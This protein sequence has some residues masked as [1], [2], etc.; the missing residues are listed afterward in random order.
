M[1]R[2]PIEAALVEAV[3]SRDDLEREIGVAPAC[4]AYPGGSFGAG[5]PARLAAAGFRAAFTTQRGVNDLGTADPLLLRRIN[6]GRSTSPALMRAE[7]LPWMTIVNRLLP[8][9]GRH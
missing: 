8:V 7:L 3:G 4:F 6:V 1:Q 2:L 9:T 5:L